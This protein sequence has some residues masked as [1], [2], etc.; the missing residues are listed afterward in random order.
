MGSDGARSFTRCCHS[1]RR[2]RAAYTWRATHHS[3][4]I[5]YRVYIGVAASGRRTVPCVLWGS[6]RR[7]GKDRQA[8]KWA[9]M[10]GG[11]NSRIPIS[12]TIFA[13]YSPL[14]RLALRGYVHYGTTWS[15]CPLFSQSLSFLATCIG[16]IRL[17]GSRTGTL[18]CG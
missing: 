17:V 13:F 6:R 4:D 14:F 15:Y 16:A 7:N 3:P 2:L 11:S 5:D 8:C 18:I 9:S 12:F 1:L 10:Q